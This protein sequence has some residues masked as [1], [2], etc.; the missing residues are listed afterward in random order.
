MR[1]KSF[2]VSLSIVLSLPF[3]FITNSYAAVTTARLAGNDRYSTAL[4]ISK[5]GWQTAENAVIATGEDFP[6]ALC[7]APLARQFDAPILL[8]G[9][10]ALNAGTDAELTRLNVKNVYIIGGEGVISKDIQKQ[11]EAKGI[12]CIRIA[13]KDRYATSVEVA[14]YFK[15]FNEIAVAT[16]RDFPDALSIAPIAAKK[17]IPI[18]LTDKSNLPSNVKAFLADRTISKAYVIGGTGVISDTVKNQVPNSERICGSNRFETNTS[19]LRYFENEL[20]YSNAYLATGTNFPDALAGSAL[21]AKTGSSIILTNKIPAQTTKDFI[22]SKLS[23]ISKLNVLGGNGVV[24]LGTVNALLYGN[25][26]L[27]AVSYIDVG[28]ADSILITTPDN[29]VML[30]D[31]GNAADSDTVANYLKSRGISKIDV[32]IGTHP[33]EDHVG[34][35]TTVVNNFDIEKIYMPKVTTTTQAFENLITAI[36]DKGLSVTEPVPGTTFSLGDAQFTILAPNNS[37]YEDLNNYSVVLRMTYGSNSFLFTGDAEGLS[38]NEMLAGGYTLSADVLKVGHHGSNSSTSTAFLNAVN[39]KYAVI[40]VGKGNDYGHPAQTTIDK[41]NSK[42]IK[43]FRTDLSGTIIASSDGYNITFN[44][45]PNAGIGSQG[46]G[47]AT[48]NATASIDVTR[49][50]QNSTI[51]LTVTGPAGST[52][53]AVCHYKSKDTP[54]NGIIGTDNKLV[55]PIDIGRAAIGYEVKIDASVISNGSTAKV[56]TSFIPQ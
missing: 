32:L 34:G 31:A 29:K 10:A 45:T 51:H 53:N 38:E 55:L 44:T 33:H 43:V 28:Q 2:L 49:P 35:M 48:S 46:S 21:A 50:Q 9:K 25:S 7:A 22:S 56:Q 47:S 14:K 1:I 26:G 54:Y 11:I 4:E 39:P 19:I 12:I 30:I 17:N 37:S 15:E 5:E 24:T 3:L 6:D 52:V 36:S 41:L 42:G 18:I 20:N 16:G 40:S 13:G 27:L 23:S 8:T